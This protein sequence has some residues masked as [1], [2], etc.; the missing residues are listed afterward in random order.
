MTVTS[1][2][3]EKVTITVFDIL[4]RPVTQ[5]IQQKNSN[6]LRISIPMDNLRN[7]IYVVKVSTAGGMQ[8]VKQVVKQ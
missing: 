7:G 4:G 3:E 2:R 8:S 1:G 6:V 5:A